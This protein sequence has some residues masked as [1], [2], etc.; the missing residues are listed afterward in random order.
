MSSVNKTMNETIW[1]WVGFNVFVLV[2]GEEEI[3]GEHNPV[4]RWFKKLMPVGG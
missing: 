4:V 2:K 3:H 1:P